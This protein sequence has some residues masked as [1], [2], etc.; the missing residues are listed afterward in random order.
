MQIRIQATNGQQQ[1][2]ETHVGLE[3]QSSRRSFR[4]SFKRQQSNTSTGQSPVSPTIPINQIPNDTNAIKAF[5]NSKFPGAL[6]L[7][8]YQ[9]NDTVNIP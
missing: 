1:Q 3:K 2:E 4:E 8:E 7:E 6:L 5:I 9:V